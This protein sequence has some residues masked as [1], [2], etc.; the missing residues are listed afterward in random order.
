MLCK[1]IAFFGFNLKLTIEIA[2][3]IVNKSKKRIELESFNNIEQ[4]GKELKDKQISI[5]IM[6]SD[7]PWMRNLPEGC[8]DT[9]FGKATI[10]GLLHYCR[11]LPPVLFQKET[12]NMQEFEDFLLLI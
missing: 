9:T 4:L 5:V 8:H 11:D 6:N 7:V 1:K 10:K 3:E 12:L 2:T